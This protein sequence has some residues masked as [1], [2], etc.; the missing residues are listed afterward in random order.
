[1]TY[2]YLIYKR[3][4]GIGSYHALGTKYRYYLKPTWIPS[5]CLFIKSVVL[6]HC[7]QTCV[8]SG[9]SENQIL[10]VRNTANV[11]AV[12]RCAICAWSELKTNWR[13]ELTVNLRVQTIVKPLMQ[14]RKGSYFTT[15]MN[16]FRVFSLLDEKEKF[17]R[18][19]NFFCVSVA[20]SFNFWKQVT[21]LHKT[22]YKLHTIWVYPSDV[23][24][25][26][27]YN[28]YN[29]KSLTVMGLT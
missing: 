11:C 9:G 15:Y 14:I 1:M 20:P 22:S 23:I 3:I 6:C 10:T 24:F 26:L 4:W 18:S 28:Q 12:R 27:S 19:R 29:R 17:M 16:I 25:I 7:Q 21:D 2:I 5:V 13:N 8:N